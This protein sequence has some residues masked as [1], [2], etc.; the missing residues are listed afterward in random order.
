MFICKGSKFSWFVA[1]YIYI[2]IANIFVIVLLSHQNI[3]DN[4]LYRY[5]DILRICF[6][7]VYK[8]QIQTTTLHFALY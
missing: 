8:L 7:F 6:G 4:L 3:I 5:I 1:I 2:Y